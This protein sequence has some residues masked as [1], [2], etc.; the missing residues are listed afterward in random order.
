[1][2]LRHGTGERKEASTIVPVTLTPGI[3]RNEVLEVPQTTPGVQWTQEWLHYRTPSVSDCYD[4]DVSRFGEGHCSS[5]S[6][7][8]Q[9]D[10]QDQSAEDDGGDFIP[11]PVST[12]RSVSELLQAKIDKISHCIAHIESKTRKLNE[13]Y[14][15]PPRYENTEGFC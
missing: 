7:E 3:R 14:V 10:I 13:A 11:P 4:F 2:S 1:M 6:S 5:D 8:P 15:Q 9:M 12:Q